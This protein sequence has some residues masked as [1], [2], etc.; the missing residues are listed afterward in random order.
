MAA[1]DERTRCVLTGRK[2]DHAAAG[3]RAGVYGFLNGRPGIGRF[4]ARGSVVL[5]IENCLGRDLGARDWS[6][7]RSRLGKGTHSQE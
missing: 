4:D 6:R 1:E 2:V 3:L 7:A 5:D